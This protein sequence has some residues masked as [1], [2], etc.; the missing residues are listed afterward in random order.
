LLAGE[1][2][3]AAGFPGGAFFGKSGLI[4]FDLL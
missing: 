4:W 1:E 3:S 2:K